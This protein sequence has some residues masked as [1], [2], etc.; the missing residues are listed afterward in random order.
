MP[1]FILLTTAELHVLNTELWDI[2]CRIVVNCVLF[3]NDFPQGRFIKMTVLLYF[4]RCLG[5][6]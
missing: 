3:H 1:F 5:K 4:K 2:I 6:L